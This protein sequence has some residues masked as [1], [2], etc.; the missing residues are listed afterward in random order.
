MLLSSK[1][2]TFVVIAIARL[3]DKYLIISIT[4]FV[5]DSP[6]ARAST[7]NPNPTM[8]IMGNEALK[9]DFAAVIKNRLL[10]FFHA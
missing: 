8:L 2:I 5:F 4:T 3:K 7:I 9:M 1:V 10:H 6:V